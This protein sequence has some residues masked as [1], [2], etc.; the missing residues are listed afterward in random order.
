MGSEEIVDTW[1]IACVLEVDWDRWINWIR[2]YFEYTILQ[3][4]WKYYNN[5]HVTEVTISG[6]DVIHAKVSGSRT[7]K[8]HIDLKS[9]MRSTCSCPYGFNCKHMAAVL[10]E[11]AE[12]EGF[13]PKEFLSGKK[14]HG[15]TQARIDLS[16]KQV[17]KLPE[18]T[19]S[20]ADWRAYFEKQ[21]GRS[22]V[23][24]S[25]ALE[26]LFV[27]AWGEMNKLADA[28]EPT[29]RGI[30]DIQV[31]LYLMQLCDTLAESKSDIFD[32]SYAA[33]YYFARITSGCREH[34]D[35][36][37]RGRIRLLRLGDFNVL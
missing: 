9:F 30:Y 13:E 12:R 20:C 32:F 22:K 1:G 6:S 34:L 23:T 33:P 27:R 35:A 14:S 29:I 19:D 37:L 8:V 26:G 16:P 31:V 21:L 15:A 36:A 28:W 10:F 18:A 17:V 3:R 4:G 2:S 5:G 25:H 7:Y 24:Y 11:V